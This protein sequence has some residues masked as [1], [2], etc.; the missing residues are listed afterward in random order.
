MQANGEV[1]GAI[2]ACEFIETSPE[3]IESSL[4]LNGI[5]N[6][7][8]KCMERMKN[9]EGFHPAGA[10]STHAGAEFPRA[11]ADLSRTGADFYHAGAENVTLIPPK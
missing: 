3:S 4:D 7:I 6:K 10:E 1:Q 5:L 8:R 11:G 9:G 2:R